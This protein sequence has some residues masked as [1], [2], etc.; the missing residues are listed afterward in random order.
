MKR[1]AFTLLATSC[2][3]AAGGCSDG[4]VTTEE[5]LSACGG[6]AGTYSGSYSDNSCHGDHT[7]GSISNFQISDGCTSEIQGFIISANGSITG[8]DETGNSFDVRAETPP[9]STC[10][11]LSGSCTR[12]GEKSYHCNY[13]W[14]QGGGGS[15][16]VSRL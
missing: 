15:L 12:T 3:L 14:D 1:L 2:L 11:G 13:T 6:I 10:G 7:Q 8:I 16:D 9:G 4:N 5:V